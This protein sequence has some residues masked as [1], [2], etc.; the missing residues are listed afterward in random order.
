MYAFPFQS[1]SARPT[2]DAYGNSVGGYGGN[3]FHN[4]GQQMGGPYGGGGYG[5]RGGGR[6]G[7]GGGRGYPHQGGRGGMQDNYGGGYDIYLNDFL[8]VSCFC[9]RTLQ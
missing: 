1:H 5:G 9:S 4:Q 8:C 7:L 3:N 6:G 2:F